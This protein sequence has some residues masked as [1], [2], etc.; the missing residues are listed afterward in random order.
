MPID[1]PPKLWLPLKPAIIRAASMK[2]V[3]RAMPLMTT[4]AAASA[5]ALR[6]KGPRGT[7]IVSPTQLQTA[8]LAATTVTL[9][10][11]S[12]PVP[13]GALIIACAYYSGT[14]AAFT[15][16]SGNTYTT[17][18][19]VACNNNAALYGSIRMQYAVNA[20]AAVTSI[21][22]TGDTSA[23][24]VVAAIFTTG[25]AGS[26]LDSG[27]TNTAFGNGNVVSVTS[28]V[29]SAANHLFIG[30]TGLALN[31]GTFNGN[32]G[33][34]WTTTGGPNGGGGNGSGAGA[35]Q[36]NTGTGAKTFGAGLWS[37]A[38]QSAAIVAAFR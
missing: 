22:F 23:V 6:G 33:N 27:V 35:N 1:L 12:Q 24:G 13:T 25:Q 36:I 18:A 28:G 38:N 10:S 34:G 26:P 31:S 11:L 4:F 9:S 21:T 37:N 30:W 32:A 15:D 7:A 16:S 19:T 14:A 29:P 20:G 8:T 5:G 3:E 2:D 17:V